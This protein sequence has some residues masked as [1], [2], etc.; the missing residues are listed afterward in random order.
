VEFGKAISILLVVVAIAMASHGR[1]AGAQA[2]IETT[3]VL[4][5]ELAAIPHGVHWV[6]RSTLPV[7][8]ATLE[9]EGGFVMV[10]SEFASVTGGDGVPRAITAGGAA[11]LQP[12]TNTLVPAS[13]QAEVWT[14]V[15]QTTPQAGGLPPLF[16]TR[17][18]VDFRD[19]PHLA[20]LVAETFAPGGATPP[21]RHFGP[22]GVFLREGTWELT[23]A[24][25]TTPYA[26][27]GGYL[28]DPLVPHQLRNVGT[29]PAR[30]FNLSLVPAGQ[31]AGEALPASALRQ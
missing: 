30:L 22:E 2:P 3:V 16:A 10:A 20:R 13:A 6:V 25:V 21:H 1:D 14:F 26:G 28:A 29:L 7:E 24:G 11:W 19:G 15:L 5:S 18:L 4:V 23:Y 8:G 17:E 31:P 9:H 27:G 12:G